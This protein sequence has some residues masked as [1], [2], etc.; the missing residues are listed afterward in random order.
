MFFGYSKVH[1][2]FK[3]VLKFQMGSEFDF[4]CGNGKD[5][6]FEAGISTGFVHGL[7]YLETGFANRA[8]ANIVII[9]LDHVGWRS[10][11]VQGT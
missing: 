5:A 11:I 3:W 4:G 1:F 7:Q 10:A 2:I 9:D 6:V 8:V